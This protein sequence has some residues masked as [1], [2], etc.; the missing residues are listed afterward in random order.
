MNLAQINVED[1]KV[2]MSY[3]RTADVRRVTRIAK[4]WDDMKANI[5]HVS[6]RPDGYYVMDGNHTRLACKEAGGKELLCRIYEGLSKEEE[7]EIFTELNLSQKKPNFSELLRAKAIASNGLERSYL[8]LLDVLEI[9]YTLNGGGTSTGKKLR[10]HAA[11]ISVF[12][13]TSFEMMQRAL[14]TAKKA[15]DDRETFYQSGYFP[16]LCLTVIKHPEISDSRLIERVKKHTSSQVA[17]IADKYKSLQTVH[18]GG[19]RSLT[20]S[21]MNAY[22]EIY[23][24]GLRTNRIQTGGD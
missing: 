21:F 8:N 18:T 11:L 9:P 16:G 20:V 5:I 12:R 7:A 19:G 24:K 10:C 1:M 6:K 3:Q 13:G 2:D 23:N 22:V 17:E 15:T 14:L 4:N